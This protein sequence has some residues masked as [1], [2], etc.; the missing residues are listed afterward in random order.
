MSLPG[1]LLPSLFITRLDICRSCFCLNTFGVGQLSVVN[2]FCSCKECCSAAGFSWVIHEVEG[3]KHLLLN[4][5]SEL[6]ATCRAAYQRCLL[7]SILSEDRFGRSTNQRAASKQG[8]F[9]L[10]STITAKH[11]LS[12]HLS[13]HRQAEQRWLVLNMASFL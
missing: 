7:S 3:A 10:V 1:E 9:P 5:H 2:G 13:Q 8:R 6:Y 4:E 11:L 12:E